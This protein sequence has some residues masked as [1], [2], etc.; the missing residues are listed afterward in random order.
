MNRVLTTVQ[1]EFGYQSKKKQQQKKIASPNRFKKM[2][3]K[4]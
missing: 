2:I 1:I 4:T 3:D